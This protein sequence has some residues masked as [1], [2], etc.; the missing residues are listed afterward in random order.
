MLHARA[1]MVVLNVREDLGFVLESSERRTMK[2]PRCIS[3][4]F[5]PDIVFAA[6]YF[7]VPGNEFF[8][9]RVLRSGCF[10]YETVSWHFVFLRNNI[11]LQYLGGF[12]KH[13]GLPTVTARI[14]DP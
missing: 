3:F 9:V 10:M 1:D 12:S 11:I 2:E 6:W 14:A 8:P 7:A 13:C 4:E 5:A